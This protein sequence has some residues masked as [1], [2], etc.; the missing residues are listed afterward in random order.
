MT[1]GRATLSL[2]EKALILGAGASAALIAGAHGF[3][4]FGYPPCE[5]CLD[6]REAHWTALAVAAAG[7]I[8]AFAFKAR[9]FAAASVGALALVYAMSASLAFY[10]TGVEFSF[11]PGPASCSSVGEGVSDISALT[12]AL[13]QKPAG[14]ACNEAPWRL[15]GVSMA[16]YNFLASAGLFAFALSGAVSATRQARNARRPSAQNGTA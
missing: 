11:W 9:L 10:H 14:P 8:S 2:V 5:L 15:F 16:G 4:R 3:E 1:N 12:Q 13:T 6:Q 7:I